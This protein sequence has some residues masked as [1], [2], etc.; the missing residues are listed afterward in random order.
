[1]NNDNMARLN[2]FSILPS[3]ILYSKLSD[4]SKLVWAYIATENFSKNKVISNKMISDDFNKSIVTV[5]RSISELFHGGFISIIYINNVRKIEVVKMTKIA[6]QNYQ[7]DIA[8]PQ[9]L[10]D[11]FVS[12]GMGAKK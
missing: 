5:S 6:D 2:L 12:I 10:N 11:F 9:A 7:I 4:F 8:I 3:E 1:M